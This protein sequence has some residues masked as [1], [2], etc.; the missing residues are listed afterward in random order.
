MPVLQPVV[1]PEVHVFPVAKT[2]RSAQA[3]DVE[4][5][6]A[7]FEKSTS[8]WF[9]QEKGEGSDSLDMLLVT[10]KR[11]TRISTCHLGK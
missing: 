8:D 5:T 1:V 6:V 9:A 11:A 4:F 3:G 10:T 2:G 7:Y